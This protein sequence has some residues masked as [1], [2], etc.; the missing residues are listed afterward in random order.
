MAYVLE[1]LLISAYFFRQSSQSWIP[2]DF[3]DNL[4]KICKDSNY[5]IR[6]LRTT[7]LQ[8][9]GRSTHSEFRL[10][11]L[12]RQ[13]VEVETSLQ[14]IDRWRKKVLPSLCCNEV[15]GRI[16]GRRLGADNKW[17]RCAC[18]LANS[19][20]ETRLSCHGEV[21]VI[22]PAVLDESVA[23]LDS[24]LIACEQEAT[25]VISPAVHEILTVWDPT[26][27]K[28]DGLRV[29]PKCYL[30]ICASNGTPSLI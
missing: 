5:G 4:S 18:S 14:D 30:A 8:M 9:D 25:V 6:Y 2:Q 20:I 12:S 29:G 24:G 3:E 13:L 16:N 22:R 26:A 10:W 23:I 19:D 1:L 27:Q 15:I 17:V 7:T 11:C 21:G 28:R